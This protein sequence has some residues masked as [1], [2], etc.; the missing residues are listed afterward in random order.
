MRTYKQVWD[1]GGYIFSELVTDYVNV[2]TKTDF[3]NLF[4]KENGY[5]S[6]HD[7]GKMSNFQSLTEKDCRYAPRF[8]KDLTS[9]IRTLYTLLDAR[10]KAY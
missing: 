1:K 9:I 6:Q 3:L 5:L 10:A 2:D 4:T 8:P 7:S